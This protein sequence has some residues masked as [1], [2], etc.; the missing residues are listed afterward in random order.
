MPPTEPPILGIESEP[1]V[2]LTLSSL[3]PRITDAICLGDSREIWIVHVE[4]DYNPPESTIGNIYLNGSG[5]ATI[6][7]GDVGTAGK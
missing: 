1:P 7:S 5:D 3:F 2:L 6:D 4:E